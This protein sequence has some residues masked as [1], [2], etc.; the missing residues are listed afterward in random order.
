MSG[1]FCFAHIF[2]GGPALGAT[3]LSAPCCSEPPMLVG[4]QGR[5]HAALP[6]PDTDPRRSAQL[7]IGRS[8][9]VSLGMT[10]LN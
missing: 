5:H 7:G 6:G 4:P 2:S 8:N 1:L 10:S 3:A 9:T